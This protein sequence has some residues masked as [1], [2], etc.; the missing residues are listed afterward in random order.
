M[1]LPISKKYLDDP[2][3]NIRYAYRSKTS[4]TV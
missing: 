1:G 4:R 3:D 2:N